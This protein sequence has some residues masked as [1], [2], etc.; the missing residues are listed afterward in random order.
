M[1]FSGYSFNEGVIRFSEI[2]PLKRAS[3]QN[4][5][6]KNRKKYKFNIS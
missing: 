6:I 1:C 5:T 4:G 3:R 2:V